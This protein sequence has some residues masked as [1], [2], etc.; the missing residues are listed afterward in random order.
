MQAFLNLSAG[1][2]KLGFVFRDRPFMSFRTEKPFSA[3]ASDL[4]CV[5]G[6]IFL[7]YE[8]LAN[9]E[10]ISKGGSE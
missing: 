4:R 10:K 7:N 9:T 2:A 8:W 6:N 3:K 5:M 1:A